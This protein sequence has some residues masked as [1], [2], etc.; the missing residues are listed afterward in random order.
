MGYGSFRK[1]H[2]KKTRKSFSNLSFTTIQSLKNWECISGVNTPNGV[3]V[4]LLPADIDHI[5][6]LD[7]GDV[8]ETERFEEII[9]KINFIHFNFLSLTGSSPMKGSQDNAAKNG[10]FMIRK[11]HAT[12]EFLFFLRRR[13]FL[14]APP[15]VSVNWALDMCVK[16]LYYHIN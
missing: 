3:A 5:L 13:Q 6:F 8:V 7:A 4:R 9:G 2:A 16:P 12:K 15:A 11:E 14:P 1:T 10:P